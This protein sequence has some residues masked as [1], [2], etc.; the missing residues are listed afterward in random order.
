MRT[1]H[2]LTREQ[3]YQIAA[4]RAAGLNQRETAVLVGVHKSTISRE[5]RRNRNRTHRGY[6]PRHAHLL[7]LARRAARVRSLLTAEHW[8]WVRKL[9][10]RRWSP[11]Q[12]AGRSLREG[13]F[14]VSHEWIYRYVL[15]DR[16]AGGDLH[17]ALRSQKARRKRYARLRRMRGE[18]AA[19]VGIRER[20]GIVETRAR[21][22]DWEG[23]TVAGCRWRTGIVTLVE[24]ASRYSVLGRLRGKSAPH[25]AAAV[26]RC[27]RSLNHKALSLTLDNGQ[28][29]AHHLRITD[30]LNVPVFFADP[31][32]PWQRGTVENTNGLLRQYFPKTLDFTTITARQLHRAQSQLNHRPRKCLGYRTP[33]EVFFNTETRL[34][35]ALR[36]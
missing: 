10:R 32:S 1:Y 22:G 31:R 15:R 2:Q 30:A 18:I 33:Y 16:R 11:E 35:G 3:R 26:T 9:L 12:I 7:A 23:D 28:E 21:I 5:L 29:F 24:R 20:P 14:R 8:T 25:T 13:R 19:R 27:L 4:L 6:L 36:G 17:Q 34:I